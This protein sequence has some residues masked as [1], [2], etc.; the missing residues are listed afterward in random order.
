MK[1]T[2]NYK[3][4]FKISLLL[5]GVSI[6]F[7]FG[8]NATSAAN[9]PNIYVNGSS[10]NDNWNG[11][12][13]TWINTTNG[14]KATIQNATGTVGSNGTVKVA[15]GTYDETGI[16]INTNMQIVGENQQNTIIDGQ[17]TGTTVFTIDQGVK[18]T[19]ENLTFMNTMDSSIINNGILTIINCTFLNNNAVNGAA[20]NN[21]GTLDISD[22]TFNNNT[23]TVS[24]MASGGGAIYNSGNLNIETS[25]FNNDTSDGSGLGMGGAIVNIGNLYIDS[26]SFNADGLNSWDGGA[27]ANFGNCT[28]TNSS[29]FNNTCWDAGAI[30]NYYNGVCNITGTNFTDNDGGGYAGAIDNEYII[31]V[32]HCNFTNNYIPYMDG[33]GA[34]ANFDIATFNNSVFIGNNA[35]DAYYG[36]GAI[37]DYASYDTINNCTFINNTAS[38]GGAIYT[39]QGGVSIVANS[40]IIGNNATDGAAVY[41]DGGFDT[42]NFNTIMGNTGNSQVYNLDA[43][44]GTVDARYNWWGSN[45]DPSAEINGTDV[46]YNPWIV[47]TLNAFPVIGNTNNSK[48]SAALLYDSGILND[49]K[50]PNLYYHAP[51]LGH[52]PDG[53]LTSFS[54]AGLGNINPV[55]NTTTNGLVNTTFTRL[56]A[57]VSVVSAT[58]DAQTVTANIL[59]PTVTVAESATGTNGKTVT[60]TATL[61]D[62]YGIPLAGQ[63]VIFSIKG[64]EYNAITNNNGIATIQYLLNGIGSYNITVN[65]IGNSTYSGSQGIGLLTITSTPVNPV[66]PVNPVTPATPSTD[67]T[68]SA[69]PTTLNA[70]TSTIPMQ[71][72]GLPIAGLIVAILS[73]IGGSIMSRRKN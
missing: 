7:S 49:P 64:Q 31:I 13:S 50:H 22:S 71:H 73:V 67:P 28:I 36:G 68:T 53:F 32:N 5:I 52:I 63:N 12:N 9:S 40:T 4:L 1:N 58:I 8:I 24:N 72:T 20:I 27:L 16:E 55:T 33:G 11:L 17:G 69:Y 66:N 57:G 34:I 35:N 45:L 46:T 56:E 10:G 15:S 43:D 47:L 60:I 6:I 54:V 2:K 51:S 26:S 59:N 48:V 61:V 29:F 70:T 65:Y 19:L 38:S 21:T 44:G 42:V 23:S 41:S 62:A 14:P 3:N 39:T 18:V 25:T 37:M 30:M